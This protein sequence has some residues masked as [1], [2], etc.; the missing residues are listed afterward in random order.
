ME[1]FGW[2][3]LMDEIEIELKL[4]CDTLIVKKMHSA[5]LAYLF[6]P[7]QTC[8]YCSRLFGAIALVVAHEMLCW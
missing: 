7:L 2:M 6:L 3:K 1:D 5:I 8:C 4:I